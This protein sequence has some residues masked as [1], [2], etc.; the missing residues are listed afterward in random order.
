M[1]I[2]IGFTVYQNGEGWGRECQTF[3]TLARALQWAARDLRALHPANQHGVYYSVEDVAQRRVA[4][5]N[6]YGPEVYEPTAPATLEALYRD[7]FTDG[8]SSNIII[9]GA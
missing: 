9:Q 4:V 8:L 2:K 7:A 1:A 3:D 5:V 6:A